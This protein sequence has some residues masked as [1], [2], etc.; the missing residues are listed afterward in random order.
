MLGVKLRVNNGDFAVAA[1]AEHLLVIPAGD[2]VV[3]LLPPLVI[4]E[5]DALEAVRRFDAT[6][7]R[8]EKDLK[9]GAKA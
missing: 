4:T 1:R 9:H 6:C 7:A 3:R 5:A 2:N 8:M